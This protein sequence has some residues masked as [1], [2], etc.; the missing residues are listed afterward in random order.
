MRESWDDYFMRI[1]RDAAT[2]ATCDRKHVGAVIVRNNAIL[3]TGFNGSIRGQPHCDDVGHLMEDGH[4]VRTVHA[5][6][7]A[8]GQAARNGHAVDKATI[9]TSASPCWPCFTVLAN[10]GIVRIVFGEA[11]RAAD[12]GP[13]RVVEVA[14]SAGIELVALTTTTELTVGERPV[15]ISHPKTVEVSVR[16]SGQLVQTRGPG[17]FP[18]IKV[19]S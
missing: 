19:R 5:E 13:K 10:T 14:K 9:Y 18:S 15:P 2:R 7:N 3:A 8:I 17:V 6:L 11:Y 12:P 1:A 4:C 16:P